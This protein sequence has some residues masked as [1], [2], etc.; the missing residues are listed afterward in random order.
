[1]LHQQSNASSHSSDKTI[2][3]IAAGDVE[4]VLNHGSAVQNFRHN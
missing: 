1:M 2:G 4:L 3:R